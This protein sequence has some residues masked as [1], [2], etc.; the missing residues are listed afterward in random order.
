LQRIKEFRDTEPGINSTNRFSASP[1]I[2][3]DF[4]ESISPLEAAF[5]SNLLIPV[6]ADS[7]LEPDLQSHGEVTGIFGRKKDAKDCD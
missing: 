3:S 4:L 6:V 5:F 2:K 1:L 7:V